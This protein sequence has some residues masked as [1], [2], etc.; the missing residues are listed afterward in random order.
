MGKHSQNSARSEF[1]CRICCPNL[2]EIIFTTLPSYTTKQKKREKKNNRCHFQIAR[3]WEFSLLF[4]DK[5]SL[6]CSNHY[7]NKRQ[8]QCRLRQM[9]SGTV[10]HVSKLRLKGTGH[11]SGHECRRLTHSLSLSLSRCL[12][13]WLDVRWVCDRDQ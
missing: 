9:R 1:P 6:F 13:L 8:N 7:T 3:N 4:D 5:P 12:H 11:D 2:T 10:T